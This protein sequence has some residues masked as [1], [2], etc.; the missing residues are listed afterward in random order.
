MIF[1]EQS[2]KHMKKLRLPAIV[3]ALFFAAACG[4]TEQKD[5]VEAAEDTNEQRMEARN[6][7]DSLEEGQ[8][9]LV[10]A[11]SGGLMEV[12]LGEMAAQKASS[13]DVKAFG[14]MMVNDHTKANNELKG[15]AAS[16]NITIPSVPGEDHQKHI[17]EISE[18]TGAE[19]DKA[20][21]SLMTDDHQEDVNNFEKAANNVN[22]ADIKAFAAKTVPTLRQHL[23]QAQSINDKLKANNR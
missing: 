10:E 16:K 14:Q 8:E 21:M 15:L 9:F 17:N 13:A 12:Q 3:F 19:F 20:Y 5:S 2:K 18:K 4:D 6:G 1:K 23:Q 11:A 7:T 22:D